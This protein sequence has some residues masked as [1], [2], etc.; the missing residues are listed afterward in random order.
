MVDSST[1]RACE[2]YKKCGDYRNAVDILYKGEKYR[3]CIA[4]MKEY[5]KKRIVSRKRLQPPRSTLSIERI[6]KEAADMCVK[7]KDMSH[8]KEYLSELP[9]EKQLD[10]VKKKPGCE[11]IF[12]EILIDNGRGEEAA[13]IYLQKGEF[14]K[15]ASCSKVGA[16]KG[17]CFLEQARLIYSRTANEDESISEG[18][19]ES[20][21]RY[22]KK[23]L[24]YLKNDSSDFAD[25]RLMIG[26]VNDSLQDLKYAADIYSKCGNYVG[27]LLCQKNLW[28]RGELK[29]DVIVESLAKMLLLIGR[30]SSNKM[31]VLQAFFG[32][33]KGSLT[34]GDFVFKI[35]DLKFQLHLRWSGTNSSNLRGYFESQAEEEGNFCVI[36]ATFP[37]ANAIV[38]KLMETY[39][40]EL[41]NN[42]IC[43]QFLQ[44]VVH[45]D[46][47]L[48][49]VF[50]SLNSIQDRFNGY[51]AILQ[52][53][54]LLRERMAA[55]LKHKKLRE[56]LKGFP[57]LTRFN[58]KIMVETCH[59]F[60][61]DLIFF[62]Q[63]LSID[64]CSGVHLVRSLPE[65]Q[66]VKD[67]ILWCIEKMWKN[68]GDEGK[69]SDM[70]L[71]LEVFTM[72]SYGGIR[73]VQYAVDNIREEVKQRYRSNSL[74]PKW[75]IS[76]FNKRELVYETFHMMFM[77]SRLWMHD[78][79]ALIES[80]HV[81][82][83]RGLALVI[84]KD[85][86]LPSVTNS[87]MLLEYCL[88]LCLISLCIRNRG[89]KIHLPEY[90][91]EA[92]QFWSG[93][94][95][96][97]FKSKCS[98]LESTTY[99][100]F[101]SGSKMV[102][103]LLIYILDLLSDEKFSRLNLFHRAFSDSESL[104]GN[105]SYRANAERFLIFVLVLLSNHSL[106]CNEPFS[107]QPIILQLRN[108]AS[109]ERQVP[110]F[111][112]NA[113]KSAA[114]A[115]S[116]EDAI[117][118]LRKL[119]LQSRR[120]LSSWTWSAI[121]ESYLPVVAKEEKLKKFQKFPRKERPPRFNAKKPTDIQKAESGTLVHQE[122]DK[123]NNYF[124]LKSDLSAL[125]EKKY[126]LQESEGM[127]YRFA[128]HIK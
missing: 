82:L 61:M 49:H 102:K 115:M 20:V 85:V 31:K 14:L 117:V 60:Y 1:L 22:L 97:C 40:R 8:L 56:H 119:L 9:I 55:I 92:V 45:K 116:S 51:F 94:Y 5:E 44:D 78:E 65:M 91:I 62:T 26:V 34:D 96:R 39:E 68:A 118:V 128:P 110:G 77:D 124:P 12:L 19:K 64:Q 101:P 93:S 113:L 123:E 37:I 21:L 2:S 7:R 125:N 80:L 98:A 103:S 74:P 100:S 121:C 79:G 114:R 84:R 63:Y 43:L 107:D 57:S 38:D 24:L 10:Y 90:Y 108:Y 111:I 109:K 81:L 59:S 36:S 52:M 126:S 16:T 83:R 47:Q 104:P 29:S 95:E 86:P 69:F 58:E 17:V 70:N 41:Q 99:V 42:A 76:I 11:E 3:E 88:S 4:V 25:C 50:P 112:H 35:N 48:Q 122:N 28:E 53:H 46:C 15:A 6:V 106:Y 71:F 30:R 67:Q 66:F 89:V 72:S 27:A 18:M 32:I 13:E 33:E 73:F 127:L 87:L 54:G 75:E 23:S 105:P 120:T